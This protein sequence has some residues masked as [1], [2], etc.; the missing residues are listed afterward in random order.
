MSFTDTHTQTHTSSELLCVIESIWH[1][2]YPENTPIHRVI[3]VLHSLSVGVCFSVC[4]EHVCVSPYSLSVWK[5]WNT[6]GYMTFVVRS[7]LSFR[8]WQQSQYIKSSKKKYEIKGPWG[9][10][11]RTT[12]SAVR[13]HTNSKVE[14]KLLLRCSKATSEIWVNLGQ[15]LEGKHTYIYDCILCHSSDL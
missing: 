12:N 1:A 3:T 15:R 7:T 6:K 14:L 13:K 9:K 4:C 11:K 10:K 2:S 5:Y 8:G